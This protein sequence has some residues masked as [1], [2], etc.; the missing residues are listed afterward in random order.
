LAFLIDDI[1]ILVVLLLEGVLDLFNAL[2]EPL[3]LIFI[4]FELLLEESVLALH[5]L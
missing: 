3:V 1:S 4:F 2:E 5:I